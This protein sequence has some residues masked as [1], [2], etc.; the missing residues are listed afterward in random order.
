[1]NNEQE[2]E[3]IDIVY[4]CENIPPYRWKVIAKGGNGNELILERGQGSWVEA[5]RKAQE[6]KNALGLTAK[7][8]ESWQ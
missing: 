5:M 3:L 7:K 8:I 2:Q 4:K 1:L 6:A